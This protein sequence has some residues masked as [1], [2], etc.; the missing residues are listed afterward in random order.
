M[1]TNIPVSKTSSAYDA[2]VERALARD[3]DASAAMAAERQR[4]A[5]TAVE[6]LITAV[7]RAAKV[8]ENQPADTPIDTRARTFVASFCGSIEPGFLDLAKEIA[9]AAGMTYLYPNEPAT[10]GDA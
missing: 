7:R 5:D 2:H 4:G 10:R 9:A 3:D 6:E 1:Q 8:L